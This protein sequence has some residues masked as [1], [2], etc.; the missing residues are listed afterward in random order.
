MYT[1]GA[2]HIFP[3]IFF[4]AIL[5]TADTNILLQIQIDCC[6]SHYTHD[7]AYRGNNVSTYFIKYC[8]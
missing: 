6:E 3:N 8:P 5:H 7:T 1:T 2:V 4:L